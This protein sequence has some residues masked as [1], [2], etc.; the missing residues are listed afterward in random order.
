MKE[1]IEAMI[2]WGHSPIYLPFPDVQT[3][4]YLTKKLA[5]HLNINLD[6]GNL[7]EGYRDFKVRINIEM[8]NQPEL[9]RLVLELEDEYYRSRRRIKHIS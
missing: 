7:E 4:Y 2:I 6:L 5:E 9:R 8:Q 1:G 3:A